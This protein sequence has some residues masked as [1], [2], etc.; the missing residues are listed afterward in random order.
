M[1]DVSL[2]TCF[3][4]IK[5]LKTKTSKAL[6]GSSTQLKNIYHYYYYFL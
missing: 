2:K 3:V 4:F 5:N 1:D 6:C